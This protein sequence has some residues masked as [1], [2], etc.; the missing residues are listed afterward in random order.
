MFVN[1]SWASIRIRGIIVISRSVSVTLEEPWARSTHQ[2]RLY[3]I[4]IV[5]RPLNNLI[6]KIRKWRA[7]R[8]IWWLRSLETRFHWIWFERQGNSSDLLDRNRI[9]CPELLGSRFNFKRENAEESGHFGRMYV[10][11]SCWFGY[12]IYTGHWNFSLKR[13][14][15]IF[16]II[17]YMISS[18]IGEIWN[19]LKDFFLK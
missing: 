19:I 15:E 9:N 18:K 3:L 2:I 4:Q 7:N 11:D 8:A 1:A 16:E 13:E 5:M 6:M 14:R 17:N 10:D 12:Y